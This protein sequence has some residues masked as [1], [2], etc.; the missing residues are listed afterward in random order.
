MTTGSVRNVGTGAPASSSG[1]TGS[2]RREGDA[3]PRWTWSSPRSGDGHRTGQDDVSSV[4]RIRLPGVNRYP[5]VRR[6]TR[7]S[8]GVAIIGDGSASLSRWV[9]L[10][11]PVATSDDT[12][13]IASTSDSR[14]THVATGIV[15]PIER[16]A[17]GT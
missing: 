13:V 3:P 8:T 10:S 16:T 5:D 14:T 12:L 6:G 1:S 4:S 2:S 17:S 11:T 9:R 15:A 7:T